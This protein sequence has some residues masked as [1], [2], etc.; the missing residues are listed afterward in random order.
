[1]GVNWPGRERC[2]ETLDVA[3][4]TPQRGGMPTQLS[5]W[6]FARAQDTENR[7]P[8]DRSDPDS[9]QSTSGLRVRKPGNLEKSRSAVH[10]S[11][12]PWTRHSAATRAS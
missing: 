7:R 10:S 6:I 5:S 4:G 1:M 8:V 9:L 2:A 11:R 12:T 3:L